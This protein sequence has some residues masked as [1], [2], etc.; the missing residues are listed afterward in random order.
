MVGEPSR[1]L[2]DQLQVV[3]VVLWSRLEWTSVPAS[4]LATR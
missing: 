2:V 1:H 3:H 4:Q